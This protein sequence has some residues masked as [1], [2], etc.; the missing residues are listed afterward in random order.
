M[1]KNLRKLAKEARLAGKD[2]ICDRVLIAIAKETDLATPRSDLSYS[3]IMRKLRK[4]DSD[5]AKEFMKAFKKAFDEAYI[6]EID[7]PDQV[8]LMEAMK[9]IG[10][11]D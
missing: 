3:Y 2:K 8:A 10:Y 6:E 11:E 7:E 1:I 4:E 5:K 9:S